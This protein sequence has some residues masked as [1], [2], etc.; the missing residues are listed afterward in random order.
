MNMETGGRIAGYKDIGWLQR[1]E[2]ASKISAAL[3]N[4]IESSGVSADEAQWAI[5]QSL[6]RRTKIEGAPPLFTID[7]MA[8]S[9]Y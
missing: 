8:S 7:D 4:T 2:L 5:M 1:R 3:Q 6:R 9:D